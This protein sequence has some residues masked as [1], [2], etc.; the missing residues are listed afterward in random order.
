MIRVDQTT[1][2]HGKGNCF[3]ACVAS[4]LELSLESV[5]NFC[6]DHEG[7]A[8]FPALREWLA[9]RSCGV[10]YWPVQNDEERS[11]LLRFASELKIVPWIASGPNADGVAHSTVWVGDALAH[12]PNPSRNGLAK[13]DDAI[14]IVSSRPGCLQ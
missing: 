13:L 1:F 4:I 7:G 8:W 11:S 2:G 12:D 10:V 9:A 6:L 14:F 3:T 5:P